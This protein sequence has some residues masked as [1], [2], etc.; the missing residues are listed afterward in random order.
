MINLSAK[1]FLARIRLPK[2]QED[3]LGALNEPITVED[4]QLT[5]KSLMSAKAPGPDGY[6]AEF[7][8]LTKDS[9]PDT[10]KHVYAAM[11]DGGPYFPTGT[12]AHIRLI[13]K[14]GKDPS[15]P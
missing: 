15:L 3:H 7:Y 1:A 10:L 9:I 11:W 4:I 2:L 14:K 12:Q 5:I 8:K 13:A 6:T